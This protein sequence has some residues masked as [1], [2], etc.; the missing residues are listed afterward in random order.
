M[1]FRH[2]LYSDVYNGLCRARTRCFIRLLQAL[3][4]TNAATA[5][6]RREEGGGRKVERVDGI[7]GK[8]REDQRRRSVRGEAG[9]W[10]RRA[11]SRSAEFVSR[12]RR[13]RRRATGRQGEKRS[14]DAGRRG[15][16][17]Y[18]GP[19]TR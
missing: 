3:C 15:A 13:R 2:R 4:I 5:Q 17:G 9:I 10:N 19:G 14:C 7:V 6:R 8:D 16:I 18:S 12:T 1:P 11:W